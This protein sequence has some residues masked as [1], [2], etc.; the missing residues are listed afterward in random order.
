MSL[1][2][3]LARPLL[4]SMFVMG[5]ADALQN[6][7]PKVPAAEDVAP[8]IA[9][10]IPVLQDQDTETLVKINGA[11]Q[12]V[13]GLL[14][15]LGRFP[16]LSALALAASLIPTTLAGHRFWEYEEEGPRAQQQINF[17]KNLSM[18]GGLLIA[19]LD[20]AGKPGLLWRT[21]HAGQ[22]ASTAL[23]NRRR[24]VRWAVRGAGLGR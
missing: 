8:K 11:V 23:R 3:R 19:A 2:R 20:T 4:A 6:P 24:E 21:Q 18:L 17:F 14:L 5:G 22:H 12:V 10:Q 7:E 13:A 15:A 1:P 16:R 9:Q